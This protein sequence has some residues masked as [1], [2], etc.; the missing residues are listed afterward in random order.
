M[1]PLEHDGDRPETQV[2]LC[3]RYQAWFDDDGAVN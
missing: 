2:E 1:H 3:N